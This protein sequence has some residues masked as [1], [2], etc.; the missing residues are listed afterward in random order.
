MWAAVSAAEQIDY[1]MGARQRL[2][3]LMVVFLMVNVQYSD[4]KIPMPVAV[5]VLRGALQ[6][7]QAL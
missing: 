3:L 7:C 6:H 1:R 2:L 4:Q 5:R